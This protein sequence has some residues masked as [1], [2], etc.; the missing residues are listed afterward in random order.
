MP[1]QARRPWAEGV[2]ALGRWMLWCAVLAHKGG[3]NAASFFPG[4]ALSAAAEPGNPIGSWQA[5]LGILHTAAAESC[6]GLENTIDCQSD[7]D[8]QL[9]PKPGLPFCTKPLFTGGVDHR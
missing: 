5:V 1:G 2:R 4:H 9:R 7:Q 3:M 6:V 8:V